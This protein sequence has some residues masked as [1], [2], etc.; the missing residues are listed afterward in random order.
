MQQQTLLNQRLQWASNGLAFLILR[1]FIAYEFFEAGLM[2][3]QGDNWFAQIQAQFFWPFSALSADV[4][5]YLAMAAELVVP[6]MLLLGLFVRFG[7]LSLL[8]VTV[9]AWAAV[10]AGNGYNVCSN[11]YKMPLIYIVML[12]PLLLQGGG[13]WSVDSVLKKRYPFLRCL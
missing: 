4:N 7:A 2:K 9:V 11:G 5:W 1:I 10:H 12:L 6:V 3:W 13:S 8:V